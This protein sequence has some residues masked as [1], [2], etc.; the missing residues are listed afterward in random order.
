MC[1]NR[2]MKFI[3]QKE[4]LAD[5]LA[6][7]VNDSLGKYNQVIW[8]VSGGSNISISVGAMQLIDDNL[9]SKLVIMQTDERYVDPNSPDC[10]WYQ[11]AQT[12]FDTKQA[13]TFPILSSGLSLAE[14]ATNY[15]KVVSE[16]FDQ[17]EYIIG[18][19]GI[20]ANGHTAGIMPGSVAA[21]SRDLVIGYEAED[22]KRV[23]LGFE[24]IKQLKVAYTFAFGEDKF[25]ALTDLADKDLSLEEL[26]SGIL[27]Q[28]DGS[29]VY[30]DLIE[31]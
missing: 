2:S 22:F 6:K 13:K 21:K 10:N 23:T 9:S 27:K 4:G 28:I 3:K 16:Q 11:L 17:A 14:T 26:P 12:G 31:G 19:F 5:I 18:Q 20:G 8:L 30:N 7:V 1:H 29:V 24:A 15:A 25:K